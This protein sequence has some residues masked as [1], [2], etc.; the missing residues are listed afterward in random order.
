MVY[1]AVVLQCG[2]KWICPFQETEG[3]CGSWSLRKKVQ[4]FLGNVKAFLL[5]SDL[6]LLCWIHFVF[7]R[8]RTAFVLYCEEKKKCFSSASLHIISCPS[9]QLSFP[10]GW[11]G[12]DEAWELHMVV[13]HL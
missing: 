4:S 6:F 2:T 8:F 5:C 13:L 1:V 10:T 9:V 12:T 11:V 7:E 3:C